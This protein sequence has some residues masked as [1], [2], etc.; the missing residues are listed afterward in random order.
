MITG[1]KILITGG[2][3]FI[4]SR[5]I[6][7]LEKDNEIV[8]FDKSTGQ[9]ILDYDQ[10]NKMMKGVDIVVHLA[11]I[12]G[13]NI[14]WKLPRA[15]MEVNI[16]GTYNVLNAMVENKV[17]QIVFAS[18]SE[19]YGPEIDN[20]NEE[21]FVRQGPPQQ[22]RWMYATS[23]LACEN[24]IYAYRLKYGIKASILRYFNIYG[25]GQDKTGHAGA[26]VIFI[27]KA[28]AG[29]AITINNDGKQIHT[30]CHVDDCVDG[31]LK[32]MED[33]KADGE[34]FNI[35][36]PKTK[37]TIKELAERAVELAESKSTFEF[38]KMDKPDIKLRVPNCD[39][40]KKTLGFEAQ[41]GLDDG[42]KRVV[43]WYKNQS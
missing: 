37:I 7:K 42:I 28:M 26:I 23:K 27:R 22:I 39:K 11:A 13:Q 5:L 8:V 14:A 36:N 31:T 38:V 18:T 43:E 1:K 29:D 2:A 41:V 12:A 32:A 3:G 21:E 19:V 6:E 40:A 35:G 17:N 25:E 30:W 16:I 20:A 33:P 34:V 15:T 24:F 9:D 10:L 4:G